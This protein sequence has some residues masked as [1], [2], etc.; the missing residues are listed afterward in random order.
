MS[1]TAISSLYAYVRAITGDNGVYDDDN[2]LIPNTYYW[3]DAVIKAAITVVALDTSSYAIQG[4]DITP[5]LPNDNETKFFVYS[6][7]LVL[8]L[9]E[10]DKTIKTPHYSL[11]KESNA[12][13]V[14]WIWSQMEASKNSG[15]LPYSKDGSLQHLYNLSS[16]IN[17]QISNIQD[18]D[19]PIVV[20]AGWL[21]VKDADGNVV[22]VKADI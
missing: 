14:G 3:Q 12:N 17:T 4:D 10:R 1:T 20:P 2:T 13:L 7:A 11:T 15:Y 22:L 9:P 19:A 21:E 6:A 8:L 5:R 16:R 18:P